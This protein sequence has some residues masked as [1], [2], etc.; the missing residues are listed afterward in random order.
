MME[1]TR[2]LS[3]RHELQTGPAFLTTFLTSVWLL[4]P[5]YTGY[6]KAILLW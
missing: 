3:A 2:F 1:E 6:N 5:V 4:L